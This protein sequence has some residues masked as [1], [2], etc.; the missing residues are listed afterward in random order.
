M[1]EQGDDSSL[2]GG[3][4]LLGMI[5]T[6]L[7]CSTLLGVVGRASRNDLASDLEMRVDVSAGCPN[8]E[9]VQAHLFAAV[10]F[11]GQ[12]DLAHTAS[13]NSLA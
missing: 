1:I 4:N 12:F 10:F 11:L 3:A 7:V 2:S 8:E 9:T 5:V 6:L 13:A